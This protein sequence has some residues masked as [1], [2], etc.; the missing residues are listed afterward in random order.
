MHI[1]PIFKKAD[2][3]DYRGISFLNMAYKILSSIIERLKWH[4]SSIIVIKDCKPITNGI[5]ILWQ[6]VEKAWEPQSYDTPETLIHELI[7]FQ[8]IK[9]C[10]MTLSNTCHW[11]RATDT[12]IKKFRT[13]SCSNSIKFCI[14]H[15]IIWA[16][17]LHEIHNI[18]WTKK[19][20]KIMI[21]LVS[22]HPFFYFTLYPALLSPYKSH[23]HDT[24]SLLWMF[25]NVQFQFN[26]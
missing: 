23:A 24:T 17:I 10:Q 13:H 16:I 2:K 14:T 3:H 1:W 25:P 22:Q 11:V 5:F 20:K 21:Q 9:L 18:Y 8:L 15:T 26:R 19:K 6:I 7:R 4:L 12:Y